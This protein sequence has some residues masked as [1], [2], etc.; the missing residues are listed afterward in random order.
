MYRLSDYR[1]ELPGER[2]AQHPV[3]GRDES[4]LLRL[5]RRTGALGHHRFRDLETLLVPGDLLVINTTRVIP[6]RFRGRKETGGRVEVFILDYPS[7]LRSLEETG[8][9]RCGCLIRASKSPK[10]GTVMIL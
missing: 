3:P 10:P 2:I 1:Y 8:S 6:A 5:D 7:G 9:F 4:R